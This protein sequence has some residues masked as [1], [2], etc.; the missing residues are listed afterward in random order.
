VPGGNVGDYGTIPTQHVQPNALPNAKAYGAVP[1]NNAG[2]AGA[3]YANRGASNGG[4]GGGGGG[5]EVRNY[6]SVP[7]GSTDM[8]GYGHLP[9]N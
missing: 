3:Q 1:G 7:V 2:A 4:G 5:A 6:G 9:V 8:N